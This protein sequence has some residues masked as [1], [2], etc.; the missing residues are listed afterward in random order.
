[1]ENRELEVLFLDKIKELDNKYQVVLFEDL[2]KVNGKL[3]IPR[4][5]CRTISNRVIHRYDSQRED[6]DKVA[7][8]Y[9]TNINKHMISFSFVGR[10]FQ[11]VAKIRNFFTNIVAV[12]WWKMRNK[13]DFVIEE[14]GELKNI[15]E[16]TSNDTIERY[17]MDITVRT[18]TKIQTEIEII[19]KVEFDVKGGK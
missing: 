16:N 8:F 17:V 9:Q 4:V 13:L 3:K 1:M 12:Q 10:P 5:V 6:K 2:S 7:V 14:V 11:E 19:K 15:T 18:K